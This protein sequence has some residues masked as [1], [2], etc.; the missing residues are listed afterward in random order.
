MNKR[1]GT[2]GCTPVYLLATCWDE[3]AIKQIDSKIIGIQCNIGI[4]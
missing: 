2:P 1:T 4:I 3:Q